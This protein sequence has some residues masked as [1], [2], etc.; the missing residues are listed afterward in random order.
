MARQTTT[1]FE[2]ASSAADNMSVGTG[3]VTYDSVVKRTGAYSLKFDSGAGGADANAYSAIGSGTLAGGVTAYGRIYIRF[4]GSFPAAGT[5]ILQFKNL[6]T[7][8]CGIRLGTGGTLELWAES[9]TD[10]QVGS[11]SAALS[12]DTWYRV[13]MEGMVP[14]SGN[15]VLRGRIDGTEFAGSASINL[16]TALI[17]RMYYGLTTSPGTNVIVNI[18]DVAWNDSTGTAQTTYPGAGSVVNLIPISDS[19]RDALW[20]GGAGG[21]TNLFEA[22][23]N[24]PPVGLDAASATDTSQIEHA[25]G[26]ADA[27]DDYEANMTTYTA[28]GIGASDTITLF[29]PIAMTGEEVSTG[30]KNIRLHVISNPVGTESANITVG[31]VAIGTYPTGWSTA[32]GVIEHTPTVTV[33]TSP[34][35]R[36]R[37]PETASRV[38]SCCYMAIVVEY[39]PTTNTIV[40]LPVSSASADSNVLGIP[41][42]I[43]IPV[44][45][46]SADAPAPAVQASSFIIALSTSSA[47]TNAPLVVLSVATPTGTATANA[48]PLSLPVTLSAPIS[49]ANATAPAEIVNISIPVPVAAS[50]AQGYAPSIPNALSFPVATASATTYPVAIGDTTLVVPLSTA[51]TVSPA[52]TAAINA[53]IP[54]STATLQ[55]PEPRIPATI[56]LPVATASA[57]SHALSFGGT[58]VVVPLST[59]SVVAPVPTI[60]FENTQSLPISTATV[61]TGAPAIPASLSVPV[62][63]AAAVASTPGVPC[64]LLLPIATATANALSL[65]VIVSVSIGIPTSTAI[66]IAPTISPIYEKIV[67]LLTATAIAESPVSTI[68][69]T[70]VLSTSTASANAPVPSLSIAVS[71]PIPLSTALSSTVA[72]GVGNTTSIPVSTATLQALVP[73]VL[74]GWLIQLPVTTATGQAYAIL[75]SSG[76]LFA[77]LTYQTLISG[78]FISG[79]FNLTAV[80]KAVDLLT[81]TLTYQ[82]D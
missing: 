52:L 11:A 20:T 23:N 53:P 59:A 46:A 17:G 8:I 70:V 49:T 64:T 80:F 75:F 22:V 56:A 32:R 62:A 39:V 10:V 50:S 55:S 48:P 35:L 45:T 74:R 3:T 57:E 27:L 18:D 29:Q 63:T 66:A 12:L 54:V 34:V 44:S 7:E 30:I 40:I 81:A 60:V 21:T 13:E 4:T 9:G 68:P 69:Q 19:V 78:E 61:N 28:A 82:G 67:V 15:G 77:T 71:L 51:S 58:T 43:G 37:R 1:G 73:T 42:T 31:G 36:I 79:E 72:L 14:S 24:V 5:R 41:A 33:T 38:A 47:T 76:P 6:T 16:G 26:A 65:D 2:G 25:G